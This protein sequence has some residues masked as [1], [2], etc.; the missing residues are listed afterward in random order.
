MQLQICQRIYSVLLLDHTHLSPAETNGCRFARPRRVAAAASRPRPGGCPA[1]SP[2]NLCIQNQKTLALQV[3]CHIPVF[4]QALMENGRMEWEEIYGTN[5]SRVLKT[6]ASAAATSSS[7]FSVALLTSP[8]PTRAQR[9]GDE[10]ANPVRL[11]KQGITSRLAQALS[12][13]CS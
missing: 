4:P 1:F 8:P 3:S 10:P 7:F 2:V 5:L 6:L 12:C 9:E 11:P 13:S